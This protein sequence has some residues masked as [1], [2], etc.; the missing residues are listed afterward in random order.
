[1]ARGKSDVG[2]LTVYMDAITDQFHAGI[3]RA[4]SSIKSFKGKLRGIGSALSA[5]SE[6]LNQ[7]TAALKVYQSFEKLLD[8]DTYEEINEAWIGIGDALRA[9]PG[10]L[11]EMSNAIFDFLMTLTGVKA[12][13]DAINAAIRENESEV[14]AAVRAYERFADIRRDMKRTTKELHDGELMYLRILTEQGEAAAEAF[15]QQRDNGKEVRDISAEIERIRQGE[16]KFADLYDKDREKLIA[17]LMKRREFALELQNLRDKAL[18]QEKEAAALAAEQEAKEKEIAEQ[19]RLQ[20]EARRESERLAKEMERARGQ[21]ARISDR[22]MKGGADTFSSPMGSISLPS[23][24]SVKELA[25]KQ[26]TELQ[27]IDRSIAEI[28]RAIADLNKP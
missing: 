18:A 19:L 5:A 10:P 15:K 8:A 12:E 14:D 4:E 2:V 1:L 26:L 6:A 11:G 27:A 21:R 16:G 22:D 20:N 24:N 28:Q 3:N 9:M 7:A 17:H 23:L 25:R 13:I